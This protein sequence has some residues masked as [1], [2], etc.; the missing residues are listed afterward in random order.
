MVALHAAHRCLQ[1]DR[2][3]LRQPA[4]R[5][6]GHP[7]HLPAGAPVPDHADARRAAHGGRRRRDLR[8][9]RGCRSRRDRL[10][11]TGACALRRSLARRLP[12]ARRHRRDHRSRRG[13]VDLPRHRRA[14]ADSAGWWRAKALLND[15]AAI[16]LFVILLGALTGEQSAD[17]ASGLWLFLWK[18][19]GGI[20]IGYIAGQ[21]LV[22]LLPFVRDFRLA[23]VTLSFALPYLVYVSAEYLVDVSGVVG[24]VM[25]GI[26][27]NL[28]GPS[29]VTP[30][31]WTYLNDV[32]E[33][34]AFW[35]SSLIF[36]LASIL[37]PKLLV[38]VG[39]DDLLLLII[40]IVAALAARA[41]VLFDWCRCSACSTCRNRSA[42]R[43]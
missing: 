30:D 3:R 19:A 35:A 29:R 15:A 12:P 32:W 10:H 11:R 17:L 24:V 5:F 22:H 31:G 16:A 4:A 25:A 40:V 43:S 13:R 2:R 36:M 41:V 7:E 28:T 38:D 37:I 39:F 20:A 9:G 34:I 8:H 26:V 42:C 27:I 1:R 14:G 6:A 33:Q 23:Q 21:L 18:F